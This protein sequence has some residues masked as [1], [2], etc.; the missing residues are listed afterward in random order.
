M[1]SIVR[2]RLVQPRSE[3]SPL[4]IG[5]GTRGGMLRGGMLCCVIL[6]TGWLFGGELSGLWWGAVVFR[7]GMV[8]GLGLNVGDKV[9]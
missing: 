3:G 8:L 7:L 2:R 9:A 6:E 1:S 5:V 4:P